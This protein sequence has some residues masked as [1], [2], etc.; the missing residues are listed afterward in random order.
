[1]LITLLEVNPR[2]AMVLSAVADATAPAAT[3]MVIKQYKT[4][5][6]V[7]ENLMSVVALDDATAIIFFGLMV[8]LANAF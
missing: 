5:G 3:L 7:T 2:F 4:K 8:A 6:E 1:L